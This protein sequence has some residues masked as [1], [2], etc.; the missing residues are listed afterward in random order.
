MAD[1]LTGICRAFSTAALA[2]LGFAVSAQAQSAGEAESSD[3]PDSTSL[4]IE[5]IVVSAQ[6]RRQALEDVPLV[7][8]V[9]TADSIRDNGIVGLEDIQSFIPSLLMERNIHPFATTIRIRGIG[10]FGNIPNFEPAVGLFIDG[11]FRSRTGVGMA[12]LLDVEQIEILHG[13]QSTLYGKNVTAGVVSIVTKRPTYDF[14]GMLEGRVGSDDEY[15]LSASISGP[16]GNAVSGRLSALA[17]SRGG[18]TY[19]L[20]RQDDI[21]GV[22][23]LGVRG[24]LKFEPA[25]SLSI[26]AILGHSDTGDSWQCCAPDTLYGPASSAFI[27]AVTGQPPLDNDPTNR[28][29]AHND[30]Y[31]FEGEASE[32]TLTIKY[33]YDSATL[34]SL[35]SY[36]TYEFSTS[37]DAEQSVLD[38]WTFNDLQQGDTFS[39]ELRLTSTTDESFEWNFR[40]LIPWYRPA[41]HEA[42]CA[43]LQG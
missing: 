12:D 40:A 26:L 15:A 32:A 27:A 34:T 14:E 4:T 42:G 18:L 16:L 22:D 7:V 6:K 31:R 30:V 23:Q 41:S 33:D 8:S 3:G 28:L 13:P 35:T 25:D 38:I 43:P 39:Q 37:M 20:Y 21:N 24:Q 36:D 1:K 5:E 17:R 11:A 9:L 10:N 19:D 2:G 29:I